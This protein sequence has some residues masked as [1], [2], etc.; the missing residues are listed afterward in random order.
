MDEK[1]LNEVKK[2]I[3][4]DFDDDDDLIKDQIDVAQIYIDECVGNDY[5]QDEKKVRLASL[6]LKMFVKYMYD[7]RSIVVPQ[8]LKSSNVVT[9]ILD[10]LAN[11]D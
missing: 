11:G 4:V 3:S 8:N 6:I 7:N 10:V 9:T 2:Y 1:I 5:K